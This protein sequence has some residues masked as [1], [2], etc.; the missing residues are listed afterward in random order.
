VKRVE[1]LVRNADVDA[2][3]LRKALNRVYTDPVEAGGRLDRNERE[4]GRQAM[5]DRLRRAPEEFG[6]LRRTQL[7][8]TAG[9]VWTTDP[10]RAQPLARKPHGP[11][12]GAMD[13]G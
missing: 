8:Y 2:A 3:A 5:R 10:A 4:H 13:V 6:G 11:T 7:W 1:R 12:K 9:L